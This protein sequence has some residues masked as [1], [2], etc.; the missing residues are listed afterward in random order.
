MFDGAKSNVHFLS[1]NFLVATPVLSANL[2]VN[3]SLMGHIPK[4]QG[5][6]RKKLDALT[7]TADGNYNCDCEDKIRIFKKVGL[8]LR[9]SKPLLDKADDIK[10][11]VMNVTKVNSKIFEPAIYKKV[12][13][14][15]IHATH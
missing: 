9:S 4:K 3:L 7:L 1:Q 8:F 12:I 6:P 2:L 10:K 14:D 5:K 11:V 15:L 13:Y